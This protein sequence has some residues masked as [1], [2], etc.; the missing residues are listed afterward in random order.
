[1]HNMCLVIVVGKGKKY[2]DSDFISFKNID[3]QYGL[4]GE[5]QGLGEPSLQRRYFF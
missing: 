5:I 2:N 3:E 1:M 4:V